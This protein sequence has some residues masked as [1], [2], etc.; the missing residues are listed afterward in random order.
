MPPADSSRWRRW[1]VITSV[2]CFMQWQA[3][4]AT[5]RGFSGWIVVPCTVGSPRRTR[6]LP[7]RSCLGRAAPKAQGERH[8]DLRVGVQRVVIARQEIRKYRGTHGNA[9]AGKQRPGLTT[10]N[11]VTK[12]L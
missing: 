8:V 7:L 2:A 9:S 3:T 6:S 1:G 12:E 10:T 4:R 5:P 11:H